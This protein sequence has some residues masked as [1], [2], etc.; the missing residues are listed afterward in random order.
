MSDRVRHYLWAGLDFIFDEDYRPV[1]LEA[2]RSSHML[3]EYLSFYQDERPFELTAAAMNRQVGPACLLW[4]R[5]DPPFDGTLGRIGVETASFIGH[6][7][8]KHLRSKPFIC[9]AEDNQEERSVVTTASGG[10]IAPGSI[11]RWWYEAPWSYERAG[12]LVIN[13]NSLWLTVRDKYACYRTLEGARTFG[14][15]DV[16]PV[17]SAEEFHACFEQREALFSRGYVLKP[18]VGWGGQGVQVM[19]PGERADLSALHVGHLLSERIVPPRRTRQYWDVRVFVM[20]GQYCG[21]VVRSSDTPV[22]NVYRGGVAEPLT[23]DLSARLE[24]P[25]L[26]AVSMLD[27]A[28]AALHAFPTPPASDLVKVSY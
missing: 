27:A 28:A 9:F 13:P 18:R 19:L 7:L 11:F 12:T 3:W 8:V 1:L 5:S 15:P 6:Y 20:D 10:I 14:V 4:R 26:E 17:A 2:N 22:T 25:A 21:G 16:F 23:A 24:E